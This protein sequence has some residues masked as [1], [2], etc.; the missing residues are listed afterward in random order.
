[1]G[2]V[3]IR[4]GL[5]YILRFSRQMHSNDSLYYYTVYD[6]WSDVSEERAL[7]VFS[8]NELGSS[9]CWMIGWSKL[10]I[11]WDVSRTMTNRRCSKG[12]RRLATVLETS[13]YK[14]HTH[15]VHSA[16]IWT[17]LFRWR[18]GQHV[19]PKHRNKLLILHVIL[20][21]FDIEIVHLI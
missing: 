19:L 8:L 5:L 21:L 15:L 14:Q 17:E 10:S 11:V 16:A 18:R 13:P 2:F 1:M 4:H 7:S 3:H 20:A 6:I 9:G 12:K